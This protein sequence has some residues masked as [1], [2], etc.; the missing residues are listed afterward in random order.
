MFRKGAITKL[1]NVFNFRTFASPVL[2]RASHY[3]ASDY[4]KKKDMICHVPKSKYLWMD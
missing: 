3:K 4:F 2:V 1:N